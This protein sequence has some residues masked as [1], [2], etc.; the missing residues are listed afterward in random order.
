MKVSLID[1]EVTEW[2]KEISIEKEGETYRVLLRWD[3]HNG[4]EVIGFWQGFK[5]IPT[6]DWAN[7]PEFEYELDSATEAE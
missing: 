7:V 3:T 4:Y 2:V 1:K 5:G 6:P